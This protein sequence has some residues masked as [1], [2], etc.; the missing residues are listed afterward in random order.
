M[1]AVCRKARKSSLPQR[2]AKIARKGSAKPNLCAPCV[3][4]WQFGCGWPLRAFPFAAH[5]A[6]SPAGESPAMVNDDEPFSDNQLGRWGDPA[7]ESLVVNVLA[8]QGKQ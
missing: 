8:E 5:K 3:L 6:D 7:Q 1:I 4:S 2:N